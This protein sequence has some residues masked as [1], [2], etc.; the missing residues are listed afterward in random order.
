MVDIQNLQDELKIIENRNFYEMEETECLTTI[1]TFHT[2][3]KDLPIWKKLENYDEFFA[4]TTLCD[5]FIEANEELKATNPMEWYKWICN[6]NLDIQYLV[7]LYLINDIPS[8][9]DFFRFI[10]KNADANKT[11]VISVVLIHNYIHLVTRNKQ[12]PI[13]FD[14]DF[15]KDIDELLEALD[16]DAVFFPVFYALLSN[17]WVF[18]EY[19][20]YYGNIR[21]AFIDKL[22][23]KYESICTDIIN[24]TNWDK[25]KNALYTR[26]II[27]MS[28]DEK[29]ADLRNFLWQEIKDFITHEKFLQVKFGDGSNDSDLLLT[30]S[31]FL[32]DS[33]DCLDKIKAEL[34]LGNTKSYGSTSYD[35]DY[36]AIEEQCYLFAAAAFASQSLYT[37]EKKEQA[38]TL[39]NYLLEEFNNYI[40][41]N[42]PSGY[43]TPHSFSAVPNAIS[44]VW[45]NMVFFNISDDKII[46]SLDA[47]KDLDNKMMAAYTYLDKTKK[48]R[49]ADAISVKIKDYIKPLLPIADDWFANEYANKN[50]VEWRQKLLHNIKEEVKK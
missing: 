28:L 36:R 6:Q 27:F 45:L 2:R 22:L 14:D 49:G 32:A 15:K 37:Q 18:N 9:L 29:P 19:T 23:E 48:Y 44:A 20:A 1:E 11:D 5:D 13:K 47:I 25:T 34:D 39:Y 21:Y 8:V 10:A 30:V 38:E 7:V 40:A 24:N 4:I 35:V 26:L 46:E 42:I 50:V 12:F 41:Y 3:I 31:S 43:D 17:I 16:T 33:D